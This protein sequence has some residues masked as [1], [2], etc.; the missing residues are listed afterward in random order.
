MHH[1]SL[2][3]NRDSPYLFLLR[4]VTSSF[5]EALNPMAYET[6]LRPRVEIN[7]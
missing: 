7:Q 4:Q 5:G 6:K 3:F 2:P 1:R